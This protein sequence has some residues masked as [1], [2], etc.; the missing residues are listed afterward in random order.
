VSEQQGQTYLSF[1]TREL[2]A[3]RERRAAL[4]ARGVSVVTV[5][6]SLATLLAAVGAF[7]SGQT[8]FT[9][10]A[11]A[12]APLTLTL[13]AFATAAILG[14]GASA[15]RLYAVTPAATLTEMLTDR[16]PTSEAD[17]RNFVATQDVKT[18]RTLRSGNNKKANYLVAALAV[19][20]VGLVTL[21][22][23]VFRILQA[24]S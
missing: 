19:Q 23:A 13:L 22:Y 11:T 24:A 18:I 16:W 1:M 4:D 2:Q 14:I 20:V 8:G 15:G 5:S 10:P 9:L 3:E 7:V 17:A 12:E 21:T 6:G